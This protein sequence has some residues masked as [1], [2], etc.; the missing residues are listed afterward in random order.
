MHPH[1][2]AEVR[3]T[4]ARLRYRDLII[5]AVMLGRERVTDQTWIYFPGK[6]IPFGRLHEPTNW[7]AAMAPPG[8]TAR[9]RALLFRGDAAWNA[10]AADLIETTV[11]HLER[12][13][14][15]RAPKIAMAPVVR[16]IPTA[17][18]LFEVGYQARTQVLCDYL[19]RFENLQLAGRGGTFRYY[20]MDHAMASGTGRGRGSPAARCDA[21]LCAARGPATR[22]E[23][24]AHHPRMGA[25]GDLSA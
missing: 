22:H 6:D 20:N 8:R 7:S 24:R 23:M 14:L 13:G 11:T 17:Y 18:P 12:L 4:A 2:P 9:D 1:A 16:R 5:V 19:A 15:L 10:A 21:V 25:R 3:A